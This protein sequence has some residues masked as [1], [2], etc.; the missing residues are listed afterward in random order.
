[1]TLQP[2]QPNN[3]NE[4]NQAQIVNLG[5]DPL[6]TIDDISNW[7]QLHKATLWRWVSEGSFPR[8]Q[9]LGR[10]TRWRKSVVEQWLADHAERAAADVAHEAAEAGHT[11]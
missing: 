3:E 2:I 8:G 10:A 4:F 6:L 1:M 7:M 5:M 9:K 11:A